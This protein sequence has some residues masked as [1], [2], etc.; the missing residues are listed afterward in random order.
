M[1]QLQSKP[2]TD[3]E[4][5]IDRLTLNRSDALGHLFNM[6]GR[7]W[8][9]LG[10][11]KLYTD[12]ATNG[13]NLIYLTSR[14]VGQ[15]DTTRGYLNGVSQEGYRLPKGAV[16]MS[17][18]RT[19]AALRREVYLRKP[20]VFKMGCLRDI[21]SLFQLPAVESDEHKL[22]TPFYAG[23]GNRLTDALS[24]R[25][26]SIPP[27]RIFTI[28]SNAEISLNLLTLTTY[29]TSYV[30]MREIVDH[31]FPPIG[32][33]VKEG[34][35]EY[36]DFNYWRDPPLAVDDFSASESGSEFDGDDAVG[37][38]SVR[39]EDEAGEGEEDLEAS[40]MSRGSVDERGSLYERESIDEGGDMEDSILE[41]VEEDGA[42]DDS[43]L[44]EAHG[45][46]SSTILEP[47]EGEA[48]PL[49]AE[50][51]EDGLEEE[52]EQLQALDL[53]EDFHSTPLSRALDPQDDLRDLAKV[54][55]SPERIR[56]PPP[57][58][59]DSAI[60]KIEL[61]TKEPR[62]DSREGDDLDEEM[63]EDKEHTPTAA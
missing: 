33:L 55:N 48:R 2:F 12:I 22:R 15:A 29:K 47:E 49:N 27:T 17:P 13:Y 18:D 61:T 63:E 25:S 6:V 23:F 44:L 43:Q 4:V 26:V 59:V 38:G 51:E 46:E 62:K 30:T 31:Y 57:A 19:Y 8:T 45:L 53:A 3:C 7:D 60:A 52:T 16:I 39:S 10:V 9:H 54:L 35:E 5:Q 24:Y 42:L 21:M 50:G 34:G 20:E 36:T 56:Q 32:M 11:A 14:G 37:D 1:V 41:S 28:N 58:E 40:Y